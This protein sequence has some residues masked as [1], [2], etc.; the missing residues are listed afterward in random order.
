MFNKYFAF[1]IITI[2]VGTFISACFTPPKHTYR[3]RCKAKYTFADDTDYV[4][5]ND[6]FTS[7]NIEV[8]RSGMNINLAMVD[9]LTNEV[10][11]CLTETFGNPAVLPEEV[12]KTAWCRGNTT[13][14]LPLH[15]ECLTVKVANDWFLSQYEYGGSKHQ[16]LPYTNG[17]ECTYKGLPSGPCYFRVGIQDD[18]TIVVPPSFYLYKDALVRIATGCSYPWFHPSLAKC[19]EPTT[20]PLDNGSQP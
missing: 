2:I 19:M 14:D 8:D 16:Q 11:K 18:N 9:R 1:G 5:N 17:A 15:R 6:T 4:V 13:F 3:N 10:E 7:Q 12:S 20:K